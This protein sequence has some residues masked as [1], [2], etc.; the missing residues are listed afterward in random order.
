VPVGYRRCLTCRRT[1][2]RE[3]FW[4]VVRVYPSREIQLDSGMGRSCYLCPTAAC[5]QG[6]RQKNRLAR[7]LKAPVP[8]SVYQALA[9]RLLPQSDSV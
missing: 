2:P 7:A 4:R 5:L 6:A 1:A 3:E 8:D 9:A